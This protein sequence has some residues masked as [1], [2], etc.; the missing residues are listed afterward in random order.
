MI[1]GIIVV[2]CLG[3]FI[4]SLAYKW[5][6]VEWVQVHGNDFFHKMASCDFCLSWWT[7]LLLCA[8]LALITWD[9]A[10]IAY[11]PVCCVITKKLL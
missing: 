1:E 3:A 9:W 6:A 11:A 8:V 7:D 2:S 5:G 4:L 10:P